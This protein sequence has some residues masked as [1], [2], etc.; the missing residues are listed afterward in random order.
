MIADLQRFQEVLPNIKSALIVLPLDASI[1]TAAAGLSLSLALDKKGVPTVV[2]YP[3]P[4]TVKFN[5]LVG[6]DKVRE[7]LGDKNM[8][9][10]FASYPAENIE[11]VSYN[12]EN[13]QFALTVVPK[14]GYS[15]PGAENIKIDYAGVSAD[16]VIAVGANYPSDLGRFAENKE[17][18]ERPS[19]AILGNMPLAGW[20]KAIEL[21]DPQATS[22]TEV[23]Y[24]LIGALQLPFDEDV[25]TNLLMGLTDGTQNF[26]SLSV[27]AN[28]FTK[29]AQL[30]QAGARKAPVVQAESGNPLASLNQGSRSTPVDVSQQQFRDSTNLG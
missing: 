30:M 22:V 19:L 13:N 2:A 11:R 20:T 1:D 26:T 4:V 6:I 17:L 24:D 14:P 5:R 28:T 29:A 27:N 15:A 10:S 16:L 9:L 18:L 12:I 21:I 7:D 3:E 23:V 8:I 25:A